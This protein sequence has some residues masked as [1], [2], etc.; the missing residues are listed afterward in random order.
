MPKSKKNVRSLKRAPKKADG[1][2]PFSVVSE[3][4]GELEEQALKAYNC[5]KAVR[6]RGEPDWKEWV[7]GLPA[8]DW[9]ALA[10]AQRDRVTSE[11]KQL[12]NEILSKIHCA[13][14]LAGKEGILTEAKKSL[15][16]IVGKVESSGIVDKAV[17]TAIHTKDGLL[18]FLNIPTHEEMVKLQ[19]RLSH[20][21]RKLTECSKR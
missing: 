16:S 2:N 12:S 21:E 15:E 14:V 20:L 17:D 8:K 19:R 5:I 9:M 18:A 10:G 7:E 6:K 3:M 1:Q 4:L 11:I 13:D